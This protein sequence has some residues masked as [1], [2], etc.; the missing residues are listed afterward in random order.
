MDLDEKEEE[1]AVSCGVGGTAAGPK[2]TTTMPPHKKPLTGT[3]DSSKNDHQDDPQTQAHEDEIAKLRKQVQDLQNEKKE[4]KDFACKVLSTM[5]TRKIENAVVFDKDIPDQWKSDGEIVAAAFRGRHVT[6]WKLSEDLKFDARVAAALFE[7]CGRKEGDVVDGAPISIANRGD[8]MLAA[9][10][11]EGFTW[12]AAMRTHWL[13]ARRSSTVTPKMTNSKARLNS[14]HWTQVLLNLAT[15]HKGLAIFATTNGSSQADD[16]PCLVDRV[17]MK[18]RLED[19]SYHQLQ[20]WNTLLPTELQ[21]DIHFV[22]NIKVF[23]SK[24]LIQDIFAR[25]AL[26]PLRFELDFWRKIVACGAFDRALLG[27][28]APDAILSDRALMLDASGRKPPVLGLP[29]LQGFAGDR[30]FLLACAGRNE[31][32]I[33]QIPPEDQLRFPDVVDR[34]LEH[35]KERRRDLHDFD[36]AKLVDQLAPEFWESRPFVLRWFEYGFPFLAYKDPF[37]DEALKK[38]KAIFLSIA[39]YCPQEFVR[40]SFKNASEELRS[41]KEFMLRVLEFKPL[42]IELARRR[43]QRDIDLLSFVFS[44][45]KSA[46]KYL[47]LRRDRADHPAGEFM[48]KANAAVDLHNSFCTIFWP[49]V[50]EADSGCT[51][52][53]LNPHK[54]LMSAYLNVPTEE[55]LD[56]LRQA[57]DYLEIILQEDEYRYLADSDSDHFF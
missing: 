43:L 19:D 56:R 26:H 31:D 38:D 9:F 20:T 55:R 14:E 11:R 16:F 27:D 23:R 10:N 18:D 7:L 44:D 50:T 45:R 34:V 37:R 40:H 12:P 52:G 5:K 39:Q 48:Y 4:L 30:D 49:A 46:R 42:L 25:T 17:F 57:L 32:V 1:G 36:F 22:R 33:F 54:E 21:T 29:Q 51:L 13:K 24:N 41:D 28:Y 8:V 3:T 35:Y 53:V 2:E 6:W 15:H 47:R